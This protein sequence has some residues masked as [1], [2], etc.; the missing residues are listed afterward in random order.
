MRYNGKGFQKNNY[1]WDNEITNGTSNTSKKLKCY[2]YCACIVKPG[3]IGLYNRLTISQELHV[4]KQTSNEKVSTGRTS[5]VK[6][7]CQLLVRMA[8]MQALDIVDSLV[9][10]HLIP[11]L[12]KVK[13]I[14]GEP[15]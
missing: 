4:L 9:E 1:L 11:F 14:S 5:G 10:P 3:D 8:V 15:S 12:V 13:I 2:I 7:L 6:F